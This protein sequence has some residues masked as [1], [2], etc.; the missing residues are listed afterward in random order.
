MLPPELA[1]L[2]SAHEECE[3]QQPQSRQVVKDNK[4][5]IYKN[6]ICILSSEL[7]ILFNQ[8]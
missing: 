1:D 3:Q 2:A 7:I 6:T 4:G 5:N 8:L